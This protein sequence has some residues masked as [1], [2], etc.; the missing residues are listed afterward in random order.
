MA[1]LKTEKSCKINFYFH[2]AFL[3]LGL[4]SA[5]FGRFDV[6]VFLAVSAIIHELG[7]FVVAD[8]LEYKL[9]KIKLLPFGAVLS[10]DEYFIKDK[11]EFLIVIAG[12]LTSLFVTIFFCA[13]WWICP[14][15][16]QYTSTFAYSN[17]NIFLVNLLPIYPLDGGR[18]LKLILSKFFEK[19]KA[20]KLTKTIS[21]VLTILMFLFYILS[22][23]YKIN[24]SLGIFSV[25]LIIGLFNNKELKYFLKPRTFLN[26]NLIKGV[27]VN[28]KA[29][30]SEATI[31]EMYK[32]L[33]P[34]KINYII[35]LDKIRETSFIVK[36]NIA[37]N[38]I[39]NYPINTQLKDLNI[40]KINYLQIDNK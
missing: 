36:D 20:L 40:K 26:K 35:V 37:E 24:Y 2:P 17:F 38:I 5:I 1:K 19:E 22:A 30:S 6:F 39:L 25:F 32:L 18:I 34:N 8:K 21:F 12:P 4:A 31:L 27:G 7:H 13:L 9:N 33:E 23:F 11:D 14:E 16:Y 15:I 29:I 3:V 28:I 10:G